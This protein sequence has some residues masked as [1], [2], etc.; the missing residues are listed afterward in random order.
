[1]DTVQPGLGRVGLIPMAGQGRVN[2]PARAHLCWRC[3]LHELHRPPNPLHP[4]TVQQ[5][6]I[7]NMHAT[8]A[9]YEAYILA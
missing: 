7:H 4:V 8:M 5:W 9:S 6:H 2:K 1:M 3:H